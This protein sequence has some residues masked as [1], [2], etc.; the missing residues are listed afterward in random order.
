MSAKKGKVFV[1]RL[2]PPE[3]RVLEILEPISEL[4]VGDGRKFTEDELIEKI[5]DVDATLVSMQEPMSKRVI[6]STSKLK[7]ISKYGTGVDNIDLQV[8]TEKSVIVANSPLNS[9]S[10]VEH[11]ILLTLVCLRKL[12]KLVEHLRA[13]K[14]GLTLPDELLGRELRQSTVGIIGVG[15]IGAKVA[16]IIECFGAKVIAYD[17]YVS[18]KASVIKLV[19]LET[20]LKESDIITLHV[21][22]TKETKYMISEKEFKLM[23]PTAILINTS[24]GAVIDQE[25]L[26]KALK[27]KW[28]TAAGIDVLE[29]YPVPSDSPLLKLENLFLTP[30]IAASTVNAREKV[31]TQAAKNIELVLQGKLP[32][33]EFVVNK[34]V[35]KGK[36]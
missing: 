32:P 10:V 35:L 36:R 12:P 16:N 20:L 13:G 1:A 34:Q 3:N 22:V 24:R 25:A 30:H 18:A 6:E 17:P 14:W 27:Q 4:E 31:V 33:E 21:P 9:D 28:I 23:K 8:A 15:R 19:D 26:V 11:T 7:I 5:K 2:L 29:Q